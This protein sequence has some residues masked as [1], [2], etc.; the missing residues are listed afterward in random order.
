MVKTLAQLGITEINLTEDATRIVLPDGPVIEGQAT[1]NE[2]QNNRRLRGAGWRITNVGRSGFSA[3]R[4]EGR[5]RVGEME[6]RQGSMHVSKERL[7]LVGWHLP[8]ARC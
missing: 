8:C 1:F 7:R 4:V 6:R 2:S 5:V 3:G